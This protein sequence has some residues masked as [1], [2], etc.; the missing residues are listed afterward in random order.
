MA[1][2]E[3]VIVTHPDFIQQAEK[4]ANAHRQMEQMTVN[5]V[6]TE[7]VYNEFSS[8][9]ADATAIRWAMKKWYDESNKQFPKYLL[10]FGRGSYDNRSLIFNSGDNFI[11]T[12]QADVSLHLINS[13][14]TD[15]Y[16]GMLDDGEGI[17]I[18]YDKV[19]IGIGRFPVADVQQAED[20]VNKN[21]TYMK[22][23]VKGNWKNQFAF[24]ADDGDGG[25]HI[26][27]MDEMVE[28]VKASF[29]AYQYNKIYLDAFKLET[30]ASGGNYPLARTR[31]HTLLN[32]GL[33]MLNFMG[34]AGA[35]GW[36][37]EGVLTTADVRGMYNTK[38]PLWVAATCSFVLFDVKNISAGEWVLLNSAGGGIALFS[39][40]RVVYASGNY[41]LNRLFTLDLFSKR[42]DGNYPRLGDV[43][44]TSKNQAGSGINKLSYVLLGNPALRL[45]YPAPYKVVTEK[46]NGHSFTGN[47]T[48]RALSVN[49]FSGYIV[50]ENSN[51]VSDYNGIV[52]ITMYDKVQKISTL[53]NRND[54]IIVFDDRPNIL[55]SGKVNV[56]DGEFDFTAM[57][58]RDIR[59]NYGSGRISYYA[60]EANSSREAQGYTESFVVGGSS[61]KYIDETDGPIV[62]MYLNTPSF[63]SGGKVNETPLFVAK[64]S[65]INGINTVGSG[66]GHDLRL[67]IDD[68]SYN[69]HILNDYFEADTDSYQSGTVQMKLPKLEAGKHT[70]TFYAWDLLN[71][72]TKATLDFE[73]VPGLKPEIFSVSNYPNPVKT[74]TTFVIEHDRPQVILETNLEVFDVA[75]RKIYSRTQNSAE[76]LKWDLI[77]ATGKRVPPGVYIYKISIKTTNSKMSSK[78]NKIIVLGQ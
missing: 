2:A 48:L 44:R 16:Y 71:N 60:S 14:L 42:Q 22:N 53:N 4:L 58:P 43:V 30:T 35:H 72:S 17:N 15:D 28:E 23:E 59:Y 45:N 19:D 41:K 77:D 38:L 39:A 65:D 18:D 31:L 64:I 11:P 9:V 50:D 1:P 47:D 7:Q 6:T 49:E 12:Y 34:H 32:S 55:Y 69:S 63:V 26:R 70:L 20:V 21:I 68:D 3:F 40:A 10:L 24:L 75:G 62:D 66:I 37:D 52:E 74:A 73:V 25:S 67:V 36:T 78:G 29:P 57:I 5:V 56:T 76:N 51:K 61:S 54:G 46:L 27:D 33:F 13:Y 8:G